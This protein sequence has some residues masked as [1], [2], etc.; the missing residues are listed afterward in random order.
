MFRVSKEDDIKHEI[1]EP[2]EPETLSDECCTDK[3]QFM[4]ENMGDSL[5][6]KVNNNIEGDTDCSP[7]FLLSFIPSFL[8]SYLPLSV[9]KT[10]VNLFI[11]T[12][13]TSPIG[14]GMKN[15]SLKF[16]FF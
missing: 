1:H 2:K 3:H 11:R 16:I 5:L 8:L 7:S 6:I 14:K 9:P 4:I 15:V 10:L 12:V 13:I